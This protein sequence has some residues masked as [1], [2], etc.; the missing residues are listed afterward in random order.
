[1]DTRFYLSMALIFVILILCGL[2]RNE[3]VGQ[4]GSGEQ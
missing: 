2:F 1:M 3:K 4:D